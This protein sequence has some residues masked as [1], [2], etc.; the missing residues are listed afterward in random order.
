MKQLLTALLL[1]TLALPATA[2]TT[3]TEFYVVRDTTTQKCTVVDKKPKT[4]TMTITL[5]SDGVYKTRVE[6]ENAMKTVMV[7][8]SK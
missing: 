3:S 2:Q 6:A 5:A 1:T 4:T 7:C 8:E